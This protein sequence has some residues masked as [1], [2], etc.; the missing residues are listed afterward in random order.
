MTTWLID[1]GIPR[2]RALMITDHFKGACRNTVNSLSLDDLEILASEL[3][4]KFNFK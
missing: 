4:T 3:Y 1:M 2:D